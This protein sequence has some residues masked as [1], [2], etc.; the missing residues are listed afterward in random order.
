MFILI[1]AVAA[2][3]LVDGGTRMMT[4]KKAAPRKHA[5][6][7]KIRSLASWKDLETMLFEQV[8]ACAHALHISIASI[9]SERQECLQIWNVRRFEKI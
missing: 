4:T 8:L 7:L 3:E 2:A 5:R 1:S 6:E 9:I